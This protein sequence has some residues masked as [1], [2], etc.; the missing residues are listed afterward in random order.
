MK[1]ESALIDEIREWKQRRQAVILAHNYQRPEV[2]DLA[3]F[4]GDSLGLSRAAARTQAER[5]VFCGV[6][7]MAETAAILCPSKKV[8]LPD[9]GVG[10]TLAATIHVDALRTWKA[11]Y[12]GAVVVS[13]V[14]TTAA[15]KAESDYC[16]TSSNAVQVIQAIPADRPILFL[17]D[18]FLGQYV[19]RVS[20]RS[21]ILWP[22]GCHVHAR[23]RD[24]LIRAALERHPQAEVLLHP[25]SPCASACAC[26]LT[27]D[28][29]TDSR[30]HVLST[31]GMIQRARESTARE[32]LVATETGIIHRLR[33]ENPGK[34]FL[35]VS[36]AA[37][38][39][40]MKIITL[41]KVLHSLREDVFEV[42]VAEP[43]ATAARRAVERM[44]AIA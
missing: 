7:F 11:Q 37:V 41:E 32:F 5:I 25:E 29:E 4:V 12:P 42:T 21:L 36:E 23:L 35:A 18:Q 43:L 24:D 39:E 2:Q 26:V 44:V 28:L 14:N 22:G 38:C 17:P 13:Y 6:H 3:D 19:E 8:L 1:A 15:I 27:G 10:C 33:R 30:M 16:C 20:G 9:L 40:Y 31:E 34:T